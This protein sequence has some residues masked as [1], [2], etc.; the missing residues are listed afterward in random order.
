M[1]PAAPEQSAGILSTIA[2]TCM[3][4]ATPIAS[5]GRRSQSRRVHLAGLSTRQ[6]R[7]TST[8]MV[9]LQLW[10]MQKLGVCNTGN[11]PIYHWMNPSRRL[12]IL[13]RK[14]PG[15]FGCDLR[16]PCVLLL[17]HGH[18][19]IAAHLVGIRVCQP[20]SSAEYFSIGI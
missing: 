18:R 20:P 7:R 13:V 12:G 6:H 14:R 16:L 9:N 11:M 15:H 4:V 19:R 5:P 17:P 2:V 10:Y 1:T 8:R 3:A